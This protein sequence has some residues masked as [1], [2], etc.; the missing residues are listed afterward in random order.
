MKHTLAEIVSTINTNENNTKSIVKWNK[1]IFI[2][3]DSTDFTVKIENGAAGLELGKPQNADMSL[4]MTGEVFEKMAKKEITPL[5]AKLKGELKTSGSIIDILKLGSLW[6]SAID[7]LN[8]S[9]GR[10]FNP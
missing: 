9:D 10:Q 2:K 3:I 6:N 1:K 5:E 8:K 4:E 7:E